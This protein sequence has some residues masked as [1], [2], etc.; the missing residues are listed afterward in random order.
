MRT[1]LPLALTVATL[2]ACGRTPDGAEETASRPPARDLTLQTAERAPA[3]VAS[4]VELD[5]PAAPATPKATVRRTARRPKPAA[6]VE[7]P[8][9][10]N[11]PAPV[12]AP[13]PL[14]LAIPASMTVK[15]ALAA[16]PYALEP[17]ETVTVLPA[18]GGVASPGGPSER[19]SDRPA[20]A[21]GTDIHIGGSGGGRCGGRGGGRHPGGFRYTP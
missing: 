10:A 13:E 15:T 1:L 18:S 14:P 16:D 3:V 21:R 6:A 7:S 8:A 2:G 19:P 11:V 12:T 5:R 4:A 20:D 9:P 17:G